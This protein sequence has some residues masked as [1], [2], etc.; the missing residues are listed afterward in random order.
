MTGGFADIQ[1]TLVPLW[2]SLSSLNE[3][4]QTIVVVPSFSI[5]L[6]PE[7]APLLPAYE[8]RYLFLLFLL[9]QPRARM[10]YVTSMPVPEAVV[11]YYLGLLP[12]VIPSHARSRLQL[13]SA[14][15]PAVIPLTKKILDRPK[16]LEE[17]RALAGDPSRAHIVPFI[18]SELEQTLVEELGIP[19]YGADPRLTPLGTK[20]GSRKLF[21]ESGVVHP[22]GYE[23]LYSIEDVVAAIEKMR[24]EREIES[25]IVKLNEGVSGL[26]NAIVDVPAGGDV[27]AHVRTMRLVEGTYEGFVELLAT[28]G[29]IVEERITG[30]EIRSPS[31]QLRGTPLGEL[32]VLST[33]DQLLGGPDGQVYFGCRFPA[34]AAYAAS[35]TR[36]A[37]AI[38]RRLI[39]LGVI[40]RFAIDFVVVRNGDTW[41]TYAIELNLRKGG[42]T[43]PYLTLQFLTDGRYD[44]EQATF[45][46]PNG[47]A[48]FFIAT[49]H[50]DNPAYATLSIDDVF[51]V[52]VRNGMHFDL[53]RQTG[54]VLHM[55]SA[56]PHGRIG[57]TAVADSHD[58]AHALYERA[59]AVL[60]EAAS[61]R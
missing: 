49:D 36:D 4:E 35:I 39:D 54:V 29:G 2:R 45:R 3:D 19:M 10:I 50:A 15:D 13:L 37:V 32:E 51:D 34:D 47:T 11:E 27:A 6:P 30:D 24:S 52:I 48:K 44:A 9:R 31:V 25:V 57:L 23:G 43:H 59:K 21:A 42:T 33:H 8:E 12:G 26:G 60:D 5:W 7:I 41:R 20:S 55:L 22:L 46:A 61:P 38:G 17:I 18:T 56:L 1:R 14:G 53:A 40:G 16:L 28:Q 58:D